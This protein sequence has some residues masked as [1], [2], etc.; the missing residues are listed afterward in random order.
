MNS[1]AGR[2]NGSESILW[3]AP[4]HIMEMRVPTYP[5]APAPL[6][7]YNKPMERKDF[8]LILVALII[9][10]GGYYL[11][12][13]DVWP[14]NGGDQLGIPESI[15]GQIYTVSGLV[16]EVY[17]TVIVIET[18]PLKPD[19]KGEL[20]SVINDNTFIFRYGDIIPDQT[21]SRI[22]L[23]V[24]DIK[25]GDRVA[26]TSDDDIAKHVNGVFLSSSIAVF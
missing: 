9:L 2:V 22:K 25:V 26:I 16:K 17:D 10:S 21:P 12:A 5:H 14:F 11:Y 8:I 20:M 1:L 7:L 24:K 23:S 15:A 13:N 3:T 6:L 4:H 19:G 18:F